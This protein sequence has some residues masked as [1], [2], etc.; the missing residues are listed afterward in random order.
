MHYPLVPLPSHRQDQARQ[1]WSVR[2]LSSGFRNSALGSGTQLWVPEPR[3]GFLVRN[4]IWVPHDE[5]LRVEFL[6]GSSGGTQSWFLGRNPEL[7]PPEEPARTHW[8]PCEEPSS[9]FGTPELLF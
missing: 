3:A 8:V 9:G 5:E 4:P 7:V 1:L 2:E 6:M